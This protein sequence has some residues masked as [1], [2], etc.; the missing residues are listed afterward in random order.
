MSE[1]LKVI[2]L[3]NTFDLTSLK[4]M[5]GDRYHAVICL[6]WAA[7][8]TKQT[9]SCGLGGSC[10]ALADIV[11]SDMA[12]GESAY[13]SARQI[14]QVGGSYGDLHLR[15]YLTERIYQE[16]HLLTLF[17]AVANFIEQLRREYE[18]PEVA[19]DGVL[20][21]ESASLLA[22]I[23]SN[24]P[25][26]R[27]DNVGYCSQI[28][29]RSRSQNSVI[30]RFAERIQEACLTGDWR[31]QTMDL[32]E[33]MDKTFQWRTHI[34]CRMR[35]PKVPKGGFTFFSSY[36]NNSRALSP[37][38]DLMSGPV[39]WLLTN[40]SSLRGL[41]NKGKKDHSW[42][43]QFARQEPFNREVM[44]EDIGYKDGVDS[45]KSDLL[46]AWTTIS[47][48]LK[49]WNSVERSLLVTLTQ[50]WETYLE[51]VEPRLV[52]TANQWGIEGW[53]TQIAKRQN[54]P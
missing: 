44:N 50:C 21:Q 45:E 9:L 11:G 49:N 13:R 3:D 36:L 32:V 6:F 47:P 51:E 18:A 2:L 27:Y 10:Y 28:H 35:H 34:G 37:F 19:V 8:S 15:T 7:S 48:T 46:K 14:V 12:W 24:Y 39:N 16:C 20:P 38:V 23:L 29:Q 43:W 54:I 33:W 26:L 42:I 31:S 52:V 17:I 22:T 40:N 4:D 53:F 25:N 1:P 5:Q 30:N 41:P